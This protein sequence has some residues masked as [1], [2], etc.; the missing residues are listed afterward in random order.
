MPPTSWVCTT[1]TAMSCSGATT[2]MVKALNGCSAAVAGITWAK[3]VA[4]DTTGWTGRRPGEIPSAFGWLAFRPGRSKGEMR[5]GSSVALAILEAPGPVWAAVEPK[6]A[7][8]CRGD[9]ALAEAIRGLTVEL[10]LNGN[11]RRLLP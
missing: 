11:T 6:V 10:H 3:P 1:C 7:R 4:P 2:C 8:M 9:A 5:H